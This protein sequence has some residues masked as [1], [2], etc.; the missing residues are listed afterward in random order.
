MYC[1]PPCGSDISAWTCAWLWP[2]HI[3]DVLGLGLWFLLTTLPHGDS[4]LSGA[5]FVSCLWQFL[6]NVDKVYN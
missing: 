1:L 3:N 5:I 6:L 2:V 4:V